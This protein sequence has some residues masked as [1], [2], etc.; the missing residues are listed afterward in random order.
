MA[1]TRREFSKLAA[2]AALAPAAAEAL[3]KIPAAAISVQNAA[4]SRVKL[5]SFNYSGVRLLDGML[6]TQFEQTRDTYYNIPDESLLVGFRRRAGLPAPG[7]SLDGWYGIDRFNAF[8]QYLGGMARMAK[9]S[10]DKQLR[11][12]AIFLMNEWGKTIDPNGYF[13]YSKKPNA[14][15][16]FYEKM[17]GGLNDLYEF[18]GEKDALVYADRITDWAI[19]HLDRARTNPTPAHPVAGDGVGNNEWYTLGE[20]LYRTYLFT[21][22]P[23]YRKFAELWHYDKY[24]DGYAKGNPDAYG[25]HAYSHVNTLSSAAMAYKISGDP[26]FLKAIVNAY[27][28][29]QQT[30]CF[31]TGGYGPGERLLRPDGSLGASLESRD[32]TFE[33]P[34]GVWAGYKLS[35]YLINFTGDSVYGD[36]IERLTYN[37]IA[38]A[39]PMQES[40]Q[41]FYYSDYR[42]CGSIKVYN[43]SHW[44]CCSGTYPEDVAD[45]HNVLYFKDADGLYVNLYVPSEVT[46]QHGGQTIVLR[47]ET[48]YPESESVMLTVTPERGIDFPLHFR[49]P[50]WAANGIT[51]KING[52]AENVPAKAGT[53]AS[54]RRTWNPGDK[55]ELNIPL[56]LVTAPVD[57][58]HPKRV[59]ITRGPLVLVRKGQPSPSTSFADWKAAGDGSFEASSAPVTERFVPFYRLRID[60]PYL[61]Y[62]D[63]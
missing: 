17:M 11:D 53:W 20:N 38:A 36:W 47:Q 21:G 39:L 40:G 9:A 24:W 13:F 46:W 8:G 58:Q 60:E 3:T 1:I 7:K 33:T 59:A 31:A 51:V 55:M 29:L 15:H 34:C 52:N 28:Y 45:Y 6:K 35:R 12:K 42:L 37:G 25:L 14:Y 4:Q 10:D 19:K 62:F 43:K 30:Q 61:M 23:K 22:D 18:S 2:C 27:Q 32:N 26:V 16:Y 50:R 44:P 63:I 56:Q 5:E 41:T 54:I 49:V 48:A 57:T